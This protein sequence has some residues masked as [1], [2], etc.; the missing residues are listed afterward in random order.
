MKGKVLMASAVLAG[1]IIVVAGMIN[2]AD[3]LRT[4]REIEGLRGEIFQ[5]RLAADSCSGSLMLQE[6]RFR[7]FGAHVDSLR[8][9]VR[10]FEALDPRGVPE[11]QYEA[12]LERFNAY[13]DSVQAWDARV[14]VLRENE[15]ACRALVERH[16]QLTDSLRR[17][18]VE[19]GTE[20]P[21]ATAP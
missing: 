7:D 3:N 19:E 9:D 17:R 10:D 16:N 21:P 20:V 2:I 15:M 8:E 13:N 11:E 5:S 18:L 14:E 6:S 12:Y 1:A 4:R